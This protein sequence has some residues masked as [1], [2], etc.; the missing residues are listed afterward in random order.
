M[1]VFFDEKRSKCHKILFWKSNK[2]QVFLD[3][4]MAI[5]EEKKRP[6]NLISKCASYNLLIL[7]TIQY[8]RHRMKTLCI[9]I[10]LELPL[11]YVFFLYDFCWC[12]IFANNGELFSI[13]KNISEFS[14]CPNIAQ[15]WPKFFKIIYFQ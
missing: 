15:I 2:K 5:F 4:K 11:S 9:F 13:L 10:N 8:C 6:Q 12:S 3:Q 1:C 7:H 14:K